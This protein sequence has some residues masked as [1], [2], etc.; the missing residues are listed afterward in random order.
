M[1]K[2]ILCLAL[3]KCNEWLVLVGLRVEPVGGSG[4]RLDSFRKICS[5]KFDLTCYRFV[6]VA[7]LIET[8]FSFVLS[9][10][11]SSFL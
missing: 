11:F 7:R 2:Q 3:K 1:L 5:Q 10:N 8:N 4:P 6:N 9:I